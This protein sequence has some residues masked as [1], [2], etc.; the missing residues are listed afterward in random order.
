LRVIWPVF[1]RNGSTPPT[2]SASVPL[3]TAV[4]GVLKRSYL[5]WPRSCAGLFRCSGMEDASL[6]RRLR[7]AMDLCFMLWSQI[8]R[9]VALAGQ[10][11]L[12]V[13]LAALITLLL[14]Y[15]ISGM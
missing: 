7:H 15:V 13:G 11:A 12:A 1:S 3:G 9:Y 10:L 14:R 8:I 6:F 4:N 5:N 2:G